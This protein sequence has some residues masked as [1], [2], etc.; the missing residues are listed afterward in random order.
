M[1]TT[2]KRNCGFTLV[3]L[4]VVIAVIGILVGLLLPAVQAARESA[5]RT[6]CLNKLKQLSLAMLNYEG[7]QGGFPP[8]AQAWTNEDMTRLYSVPGPAP[9]YD[10]HG[11][12]S[13]IGPYIEENAWADLIDFDASFSSPV[14]LQARR[15]IL[16]IHA[17]PSDIGIQRNEWLSSTW[18]RVRTNYVVNAGNTNYGQYTWGSVEFRGAPFGPRDNT[19]VSSVTDGLAK[20]LMMSEIKVLPELGSQGGGAWGGPLSDT[21]TA[22][23]GQV[24]TGWNPPNSGQDGIARVIVSAYYYLQNDIPPPCRAPCGVRPGRVL[25]ELQGVSKM[26]TIV[27]RSH[28]P[29]GVNASRCDGSV[30]FYVDS[31]DEFVWRAL[32]SAAGEESTSA[33]DE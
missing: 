22:L 33:S 1:N 6:Q 14:N 9:W 5:R 2:S 26:Q 13:M 4:L 15:T 16:Q 21:S 31:I 12:Y 24:F 8:M 25:P 23:G 32:T 20:T 3:E 27:A 30:A 7:A 11:W 10:A 18:A 19:S 28:H 17:C 29:S